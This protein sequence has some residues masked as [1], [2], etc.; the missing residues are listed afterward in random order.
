MENRRNWEERE[1]SFGFQ[2]REDGIYLSICFLEESAMNIHELNAYEI[3]EERWI[4]DVKSTGVILRHKK[5]GARVA[6][7]SNQDDNKVFY[8]GFRTAPEDETGVPHI[9]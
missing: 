1:G 4:E 2:N 7:L 6:L 3:L 5:S 8:I 9:I